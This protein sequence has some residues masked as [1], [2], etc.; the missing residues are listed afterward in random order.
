MGAEYRFLDRWLVPALIEQVYDVVGDV[1]AYP[2]WWGDVFLET[3]GDPGP[4]RPGRRTRV[5]ARGF[6]PYRIRF[7][8]ECVEVEPPRRIHSVLSG[9]FDGTGTWLLE[10]VEGGTQVLLDWRPLVQ[11]PLIRYLTPVLRPLFRAN[12]SWTMRRGQE[13]V[14]P[15][16]Q[17]RSAA[18]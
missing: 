12:H 17:Q 5:V 16:V 3:D 2:R 14:V 13:H 8:Q 18:H 11:K 4:P 1:L 15:Y 6:L 9:D 10:E 7:A